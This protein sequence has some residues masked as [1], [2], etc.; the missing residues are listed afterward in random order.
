MVRDGDKTGFSVKEEGI[1]YFQ[2]RLCDL[3]KKKKTDYV[4]QMIKI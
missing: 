4:C 3:S 1:L 2:D